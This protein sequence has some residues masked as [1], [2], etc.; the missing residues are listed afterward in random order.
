[1]GKLRSDLGKDYDGVRD[2]L[3][4]LFR[5]G[6]NPLKWQDGDV[7]NPIDDVVARTEEEFGYSKE[8]RLE[9]QS[10]TG[11]RR[12]QERQ[13]KEY[14]GSQDILGEGLYDLVNN[15]TFYWKNT[16][17]SS[18]VLHPFMYNLKLWNRLNNIIVNGY[19]DYVNQDLVGYMSSKVKFDDL[20]G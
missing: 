12:M 8:E 10:N 2:F 3:V 17:F 20:F 5:I 14:S 7:Y 9:V 19:R 11:L 1:M 6:A 4:D 18:H 16:D 15:K 13:F